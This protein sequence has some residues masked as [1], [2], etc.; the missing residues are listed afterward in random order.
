LRPSGCLTEVGASEES[1]PIAIFSS[2]N[3]AFPSGSIS[4]GLF[5]PHRRGSAERGTGLPS[6]S[7]GLTHALAAR[8]MIRLEI[9]DLCASCFT[10]TGN[11][12]NRIFLA[13]EIPLI[14]PNLEWGL[15]GRGLGLEQHATAGSERPGSRKMVLFGG[16][17]SFNLFL[18]RKYEGCVM[19]LEVSEIVNQSSCR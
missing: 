14:L 16:P 10:N 3:L 8:K 18:V 6:S 12:P 9:R 15:R 1:L 19:G 2:R 17:F 4:L 5:L 7:S 13:Q 11:H